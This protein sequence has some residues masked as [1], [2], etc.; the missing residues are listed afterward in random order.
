MRY[1]RQNMLKKI[2]S[3]YLPLYYLSSSTSYS[4]EGEDMILKS[5]YEGKKGYKGFFVDIGAHHPVRFSNT[6]YFYKR[7]WKGINVEPTPSA[8]KA[9]QLFRKRDINLNLGVGGEKGT[10]KFYCFNEPALNSFSKE[11]S[12]R[13]NR[14]SD[15]Y[16][17]IKEV[18]VEILPLSEIFDTYLPKDTRIDFMS[19]D[20]EGLDY[21]VLRSNNW[22][23]YKPDFILVEENINLDELDQSEIY[24]F[25][26]AKGYEFIAKTLRTGIYRLKSAQ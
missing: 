7:G 3:K 19:I 23:K 24:Q 9:F 18:D 5:L 8:I 15:K 21:Q 6:C 25:L 22:D 26:K 10:L 1:K 4:Q 11:V 20:V 13:I 12:E 16:K 14:E 2:L 17:I